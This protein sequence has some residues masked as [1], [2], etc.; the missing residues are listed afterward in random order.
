MVSKRNGV[1]LNTNI[2]AEMT[3][4]EKYRMTFLL[5][6]TTQ[7]LKFHNPYPIEKHNKPIANINRK[8]KVGHGGIRRKSVR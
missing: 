8:F 3:M 7:Y 4:G 5:H 1:A 2:S 6:L